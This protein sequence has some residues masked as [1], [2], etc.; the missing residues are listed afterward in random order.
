M[1][2]L[3]AP[4]A[5]TV[6]VNTLTVNMVGADGPTLSCTIDYGKEV[7]GAFQVAYSTSHNIDGANA[8]AFVTQFGSIETAFLQFLASIGAVPP[9][10]E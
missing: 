4:T 10:V 1:I 3:Q 5:T 9:L 6:R 8:A 7:E 2:N